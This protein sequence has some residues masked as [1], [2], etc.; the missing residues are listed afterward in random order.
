MGDGSM[1]ERT[2]ATGEGKLSDS[3]GRV[4]VAV[5]E[6]AR[7]SLGLSAREASIFVGLTELILL[8]WWSWW[9][10]NVRV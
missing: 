6:M 1:G 8:W 10:V 5:V 9:T 3:D 2:M 4:E 7:E